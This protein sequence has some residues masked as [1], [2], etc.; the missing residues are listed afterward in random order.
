MNAWFRNTLG[1]RIVRIWHE[2]CLR[3][4][5]YDSVRDSRALRARVCDR[6]TGRARRR[7]EDTE[8]YARPELRRVC[9]DWLSNPNDAPRT[10]LAALEGMERAARKQ[11]GEMLGR[12]VPDIK[13]TAELVQEISAACREQ[14]VGAEQI[15][16]AIQELD[17]VIQQNA[18]ASEEMSATAE[19]LSAQA[20]QLQQMTSFFQMDSI[21]PASKPLRVVS[22]RQLAK[23][24][25]PAKPRRIL[26]SCASTFST[27]ARRNNDAGSRPGST[28]P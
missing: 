15:N 23:A 10:C 20:E 13:K 4:C 19:E 24:A 18:S 21:R 12:L 7:G 17:K 5:R 16:V 14:D 6:H 25:G 1:S 9:T 28:T 2:R 8:G 11:A 27:S 3:T 26:S 22:D